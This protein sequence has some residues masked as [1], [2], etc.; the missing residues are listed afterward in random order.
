MR[1]Y[2]QTDPMIGTGF[3][4][5]GCGLTGRRNRED[6]GIDLVGEPRRR[7]LR[8]PVQVLRPDATHQQGRHR[9]V[10]HRVGQGRVHQADHRLHHRQVERARRGRARGPGRSRS[11]ASGW[12]ICRR[13]PI[14]WGQFSLADPG[15]HDHRR[16][17][18]AAAAPGAGDRS[19]CRR[20]SPTHDRGKLIMA[21]GT[22]KTFTAL[23][24]RRAELVGAGGASAVPGAVDLAAVPDAARVDG[25]GRG[26]AAPV[27]GVL[28]H[29]RSAGK[30]ADEDIA[31]YD[32]AL[33]A[34]TTDPAKLLARDGASAARGR[35]ELDDRGVLH[36]P[37]DR[38]DRRRAEAR[39]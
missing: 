24:D 16:Q 36:L 21:C 3:R 14:D 26:A 27:R 12:P 38:R 29:A 25:R 37:V 33:P 20:A 32:L 18:G 11:G 15:S 8:D 23:Q 28:G 19:R 34:T 9:H 1:A 4:R 31:A 17:E 13:A 5:S 39:R 6:V 22:G 7:T 10:L 30:I 35:R 2:F